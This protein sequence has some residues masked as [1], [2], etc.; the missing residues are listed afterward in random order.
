M[1]YIWWEQVFLALNF[2]SLLQ[3]HA[4]WLSNQRIS[5]NLLQG[6]NLR[7]FAS[8]GE[9]SGKC[10]CCQD[11]RNDLQQKYLYYFANLP[12][13]GSNFFELEWC[14]FLTVL[15]FIDDER[16]MLF[17]WTERMD[18]IVAWVG[19][20]EALIVHVQWLHKR[21]GQFLEGEAIFRTCLV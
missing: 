17:I 19:I 5:Q 9:F 11:V 14:D 1:L 2:L 6:H 4:S 7:D 15:P 12:V 10:T 21:V 3:C 20:C 13:C 18:L 16:G 8:S